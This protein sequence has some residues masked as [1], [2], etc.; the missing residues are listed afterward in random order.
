MD[1]SQYEL[2]PQNKEELI[3]RC[4][5]NRMLPENDYFIFISWLPEGSRSYAVSAGY[6]FC[7]DLAFVIDRAM[8]SAIRF[9]RL[10][11]YFFSGASHCKTFWCA[12]LPKQNFVIFVS[13]RSMT[14]SWVTS[15]AKPVKPSSIR[16][17][18]SWAICSLLLCGSGHL[19]AILPEMAIVIGWN[20]LLYR[21]K[22]H[23]ALLM[24]F[25]LK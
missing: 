12:P 17:L 21:L 10:K 20:T 6:K 9:A 18:S 24:G 1:W 16:F 14:R 3:A 8:K 15:C 2:E 22:K 11:T 25:V 23:W 4:K 13:L 19:G 5:R 7:P